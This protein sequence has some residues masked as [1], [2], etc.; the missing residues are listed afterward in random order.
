MYKR[1]PVEKT[2]G[3]GGQ[4]VRGSP[5]GDCR[6]LWTVA[7]LQYCSLFRS[8]QNKPGKPTD[9]YR[10]LNPLSP[11]LIN[12]IMPPP[13]NLIW[14]QFWTKPFIRL[15]FVPYSFL[16]FFYGLIMKDT[17]RVNCLFCICYY[18]VLLYTHNSWLLKG[19]YTVHYT[20][21]YTATVYILKYNILLSFKRKSLK[22]TRNVIASYICRLFSL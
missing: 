22:F 2:I 18:R 6:P 1:Q 21:H 13:R 17:L 10:L 20:V 12:K 8:I 5:P 15:L 14:S 19:Y 7:H 16:F 9:T 11:R 3:S 4:D